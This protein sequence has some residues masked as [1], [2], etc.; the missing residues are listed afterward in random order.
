MTK[1][2]AL[3]DADYIKYTASAAG[4]KRSIIVTHKSSGR[5]K[6]FN[7]RTEFWGHHSKKAGGW[8]AEINKDRTSPFLIDEFSIEDVQT[9]EPI[10]NI[11]HTTKLM[12]ESCYKALGTTKHKGYVGEGDSF[13]V[14]RSTLVEY[15][16]NRKELLKPVHLEATSDY[17]INKLKCEV[18]TG[19]EADDQLVI[20]AYKK[21][22]FIITGVD[23]DYLGQPIKF[24]NV[25]KPELGIQNGNQ[26]GK[27]WL[28]DKGEVRGIG[29]M[30][31]YF[32]VCY[33]DDSDIYWANSAT[34]TKWGQKSAYKALVN[35]TN[36]KEAWEALI[37]VYKKLYP[38]PFL[39][40]GWR[41]DEF[42]VD[43]KYVLQ[44]NFDM[45]RMLRTKDDYVV[46]V[47]NILTKLEI[48]I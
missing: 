20:D 29:R 27:L 48:E 46:R 13:R 31:L 32:Q 16:S 1:L 18:V 12:Y 37:D 5:V 34:K 23:K 24:F 47:E 33:G 8:L 42:E 44:E 36:D 22:N 26:F 14:G 43:W 2:T 35:A 41:G 11:L 15:K 25:N 40:K 39:F 19:I 3:I 10:Q 21:S 7:N 4:E 6:E 9:P 28:D 17:L 30:F 38:E 45:A